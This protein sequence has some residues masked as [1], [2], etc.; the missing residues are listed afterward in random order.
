MMRILK[1][2]LL[3]NNQDP[4]RVFKNYIGNYRESI[5]Q[6]TSFLMVTVLK[7]LLKGTNS[8]IKLNG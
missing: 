8:E 5:P 2:S 7:T 1:A 3:R 6:S 4:E